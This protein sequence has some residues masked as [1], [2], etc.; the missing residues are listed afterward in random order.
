[1]TVALSVRADALSGSIPEGPG[2]HPLIVPR[3][4]HVFY[5]PPSLLSNSWPLESQ[6]R[7][8]QGPSRHSFTLTTFFSRVA[9]SRSPPLCFS[10]SFSCGLNGFE[11]G[12]PGFVLAACT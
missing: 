5:P 7:I 10:G 1:M 9:Q 3:V 11:D 2:S 4:R 12:C 6:L 8:V